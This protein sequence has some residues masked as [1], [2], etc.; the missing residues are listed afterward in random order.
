VGGKGS[1]Y[2]DL[3]SKPLKSYGG[4]PVQP[5]RTCLPCGRPA[6]E[7]FRTEADKVS[8]KLNAACH[9]PKETHPYFPLVRS[10]S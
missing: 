6:D 9:R 7:E 10:L 8:G 3:D 2:L 4:E 1:A 5:L